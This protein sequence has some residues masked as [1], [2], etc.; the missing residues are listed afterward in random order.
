LPISNRL[1]A[2]S[3]RVRVAPDPVGRS[4]ELAAQ[5][6]DRAGGGDVEEEGGEDDVV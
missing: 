4:R 3:E 5:D 1:A 2:M 6:E